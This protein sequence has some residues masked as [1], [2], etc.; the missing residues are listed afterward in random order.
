MKKLFYFISFAVAMFTAFSCGK[1]EDSADKFVGEYAGVTHS[2]VLGIDVAENFTSPLFIL[3]DGSNAVKT[4]G[5]FTTT[6][7]TH[8]NQIKFDS[9]T[10]TTDDG[11]VTYEFATADLVNNQIIINAKK[12]GTSGNVKIETSYLIV[13][14]RKN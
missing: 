4:T 14:T 2:Q 10:N 12:I 3:K 6:G 9:I 13:L 1:I 8:E 11:T 5:Q 7:K